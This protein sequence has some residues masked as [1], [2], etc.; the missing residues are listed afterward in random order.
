[1]S[2]ALGN[3]RRMLHKQFFLLSDGRSQAVVEFS[4]VR[5]QR[6]CSATFSL[7]VVAMV[8]LTERGLEPKLGFARRWRSGESKTIAADGGRNAKRSVETSDATAKREERI[9]VWEDL[10]KLKHVSGVETPIQERNQ[11]L[12]DTRAG[13]R[14]GLPAKN[15]LEAVEIRIARKQMQIDT[16]RGKRWLARSMRFVRWWLTWRRSNVSK[17]RRWNGSQTLRSR[18]L[19]RKSSP[20][21]PI[22]ISFCPDLQTHVEDIC[23]SCCGSR[24]GK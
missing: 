2:D 6:V 16:R 11:E 12:R 22:Y 8:S 7:L 4:T 10:S 14:H 13:V 23:H 15:Q 1:M 3:K 17:H 24:N 5:L 19:S 9:K 20:A 18:C 21:C